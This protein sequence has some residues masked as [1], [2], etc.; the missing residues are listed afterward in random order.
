MAFHQIAVPHKDILSDNYSSEVYAAKLWEVHNKRGSDEY[1]DADTF[2]K[3]TYLTDNLKTILDSVK[4]RLDGKGGGH[5]RSIT[6]PFGGGKT[7]TL[8]ALYHKCMQWGAKPVVLVGNE[9]DP[10][11]QTPWGMIEEQLTGQVD[12]LEGQVPRGGEAL[13]EVLKNQNSPIL[14]LIDELLQY[15]IKADGVK[16][17][18]TTLATQTI[19]FMQELS[20]VASSLPNMCV[21]VTLP[22]STNEQLDDE[23]YAKLYDKLRKVSGR[24]QDTIT[25]VSDYDIPRIIRRRLFSSTDDEIR[26]RAEDVVKDFVDYCDDEGLIPEGKQPSEY[27]DDFMNNYPFLPQVIDVLYHRWGT[28]T[29]FQRTRGVLRLLSLVVG[30]LATSDKQFISLGDFDLSNDAIR[31]ELVEYLEPPFNGVVAK[32]IVGEGSGAAK[33]NA[34]VPDQYRGR[35]L[36]MRAAT[37]IF[38]YS[39]SG[40]AEIN[41]ATETEIK[42]A[43][44][45]RG[46]PAAQISGVLNLFRN[47]L[48]YLGTMN[49]R[50]VFTKE[51]NVLKI[52]VDMMDN[53]KQRDVDDA[54]KDLVRQNIGRI[55]ELKTILWPADSKDVD[56]S[57]HLKLAVMRKDDQNLIWQIYD[58]VGESD[59]TNRNNLFF[60]VPSD[61]ESGRFTASL[62]SKVA[63][64]RIRDDPYINLKDDQ[65]I[66]LTAELKKEEEHLAG[67][68]RDY[69][70]VLYVPEKE[71]LNPS[72]IRPPPVTNSGIDRIVYDHLVENEEVNKS[73]GMVTLRRRYLEDEKYVETL[74]LFKT[75]LSVPG[76]L[77]P[78]SKDVL[79]NA[80]AGGVSGGE[81]GLGEIKN[82][83]HIVKFFKKSPMISF[84]QGE[85]LI[86]ASLCK[87][88]PENDGDHPEGEHK[89][90]QTEDDEKR[91]QKEG[92]VK[93]SL[94]KPR[95]EFTFNVPEGQVNNVSQMLLN[96]TKHYREIKLHVTAVGE[97]MTPHDVN[98]IKETLRQIGAKSDLE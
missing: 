6:T 12:K 62:K 66:T 5:F 64:E 3:K 39:H 40:G 98:M 90:G 51:A 60:L 19:A 9:M 35:R 77:R 68:V 79:K 36:G 95:L 48:F 37:A 29:Q 74:K 17:H 55:R 44:C 71:G 30:S 73:I 13:R 85:I 93:T 94:K 52:K 15:V 11:T 31:Q 65:L 32:D 50:Y 54:E 82:N 1:I 56:D 69:Y 26:D 91:D 41:G 46:I 28:I 92:T 80:I 10:R 8:I 33:V 43:T 61:G 53:L 78:A 83:V 63:W 49:D 96:I 89:E 2:F 88:G 23:K 38:M 42:R 87:R 45:E 58:K 72:R 76:E 67:L 18:D 84:E 57:T 21:V 34:M 20:E 25:P 81:F 22:S 47:H 97:G 16:I 7:H 75:M 86:Q 59:R 24:M 27:R 14:I 4:A 70:S